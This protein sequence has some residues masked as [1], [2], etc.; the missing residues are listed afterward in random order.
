MKK[1]EERDRKSRKGGERKQQ[2]R[3]RK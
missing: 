3:E 1:E 2:E